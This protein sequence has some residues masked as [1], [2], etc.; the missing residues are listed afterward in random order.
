MK[1][2]IF[3]FIFVVFPNHAHDAR[4]I[5]LEINEN[6]H[7]E[8]NYEVKTKIPNSLNFF[9][10]VSLPKDCKFDPFPEMER[11]DGFS[12]RKA[13][14]SCSDTIQ[15][16]FISIVYPKPNPS[17][18]VLIR[19]SFR[20]GE[21][22]SKSLPPGETEWQIPEIE[23]ASSIFREYT[24]LGI[25]HILS[26]YDHLLFVLCL[27]FVVILREQKKWQVLFFT[28]TGFTLSHSLTLAFSVLD[29][30]TLPILL[31][32]ALI[33]LSITFLALEL[34]KSDKNSLTFT[35]PAAV[36]IVFGFLHGFGFASVLKSIGLPQTDLFFGLL[37]FNLGVEIGQVIFLLFIALISATFARTA[38][39]SEKQSIL[40]AYIAGASSTYWVIDR[41]TSFS[42][43]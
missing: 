23:N 13:Q 16:R 32:E 27:F 7:V 31:V 36:A 10:D 42:S 34:V 37:F 11:G 41:V 30:I 38:F 21:I 26:G 17:L 18:S 9:P 29:L 24:D 5:Y 8:S 20:N 3:L 28:V 1:R 33:A 22:H 4:P 12:L 43:V 35:Y 40:I 39:S 14:L 19:T 2:Y 6:L 15:G 25:R